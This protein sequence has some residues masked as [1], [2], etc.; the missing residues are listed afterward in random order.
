MICGPADFTLTCHDNID[1]A[2]GFG[3]VK[4]IKNLLTTS[5]L[6]WGSLCCCAMQYWTHV[7]R[8]S[9]RRNELTTVFMLCT[10]RGGAADVNSDERVAV[11]FEIVGSR[12]DVVL[13]LLHPSLYPLHDL[14]ADWGQCGPDGKV[15]QKMQES[16]DKQVVFR[17][18]TFESPVCHIVFRIAQML[19]V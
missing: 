7:H 14:R 10:A 16:D 17:C 11:G 15:R 3:K 12:I 2:H 5:L 8:H 4:G 9:G 1:V 6:L 13:K 19:K 18:V